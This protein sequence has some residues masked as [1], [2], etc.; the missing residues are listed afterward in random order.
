MHK[1]QSI[2]L[3]FSMAAL[4]INNH[5]K[6]SLEFVHRGTIVFLRYF[7]PFSNQRP[8]QILHTRVHTALHDVQSGATYNH[9]LQL[10][11]YIKGEFDSRGTVQDR[12]GVQSGATHTHHLQLPML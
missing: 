2:I 1:N 4:N 3:F 5:I 6:F 7:G 9:P 12:A 11:M 8:F 10:H